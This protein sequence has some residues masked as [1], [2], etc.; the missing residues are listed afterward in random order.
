VRTINTNCTK[1]PEAHIEFWLGDSRGRWGGDTL[2]V[3]VNDFS[4]ETWLDRVGNF[5]SDELRLVEP[6]LC[7]KTSGVDTVI[8][9]YERI[10]A[11]GNGNH[12]HVASAGN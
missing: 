4:G 1:H 11:E 7:R 2:I 5:P 9:A 8:A 6:D 10:C 3:D 12:G